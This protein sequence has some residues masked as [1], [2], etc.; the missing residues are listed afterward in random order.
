MNYTQ[1]YQPIDY[2]STR[3][4]G[5]SYIRMLHASPDAPAVD[6]YINNKLIA[7]NKTYRSFTPYIGLR[8]GNYSISVYIAGQMTNPVINI[9][10]E[11]APHSIY[12]AAVIGR[13]MDIGLY[14][15]PDPVISPLMNKARV[16]LVHLSPTAPAVDL[17][18]PNQT[19]LFANVNYKEVTNYKSFNPGRYTLQVNIAGTTQI[20]LNIPHIVLRPGRNLSIYAIGLIGKDPPLQVL[21]PLDGSSY[22][23]L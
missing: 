21:I 8:P 18:L 11:A 13:L 3:Q 5:L 15:I 22:L 23:P 2:L 7:S 20:V 1:Y 19:I 9:N 14:L 16:R 10:V 6:F 12:T 4:T 17:A